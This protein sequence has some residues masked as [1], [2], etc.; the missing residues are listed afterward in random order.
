MRQL[1]PPIAPG[2]ELVK[3]QVWVSLRD[4]RR[5]LAAIGDDGVFTFITAYALHHAARFADTHTTV[6]YDPTSFTQFIEFIRDGT[7][8]RADRPAV[9]V[10]EPGAVASSEHKAPPTPRKSSRSRK[11]GKG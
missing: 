11:G 10:D 4:K 7:H 9:V 6:S 5:V 3:L 2:D 8:P 1:I